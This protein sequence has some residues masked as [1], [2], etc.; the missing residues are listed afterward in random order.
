[1]RV[2]ITNDDG[3]ESEGIRTLARVAVDLGHEV[4]VAAPQWDS[5]GASASLA[6]VEEEG[7]FVVHERRLDGLEGVTVAGVDAAPA[8]IV[9]A[10]MTGAFGP[11]PDMV[12]SGVN[13]GPNTG[14]AVLHSGTVGAAFTASTR[15]C[16]A[17]AFSIGAAV[18]P[19]WLTAAEVA[20]VVIPWLAERSGAIV[21]NVNIPDV[22]PGELRGLEP[23]RLATFGAVQANVTD[24][25]RGY[26]KL[27]YTAI[28]ARPEPGTDVALLADGFACFT[29]L[30]AVS[31]DRGVDT[32]D[33]ADPRGRTAPD[34]A[35]RISG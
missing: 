6:A 25:G 31:E 22:A 27:E 13:N 30:L 14:H 4:I 8:F 35:A 3:I 7:R 26:V 20:L 24:S 2:L 17:A 32:R 5:S 29:P 28:D 19:H 10:A 11:V 34:V 23:A 18:Q 9:Q 15:G 33:L 1:M 21:L 16:R 12:L